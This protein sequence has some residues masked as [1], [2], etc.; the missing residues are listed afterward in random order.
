MP[1]QENQVDPTVLDDLM[2]KCADLQDQISTIQNTRNP[3]DPEDKFSLER[4]KNQTNTAE[5]SNLPPIQ[6]GAF[7]VPFVSSLK[8]LRTQQFFGQT[9]FT[10]AW[11][12][13]V[14]DNLSH[15]SIY[16]VNAISNNTAPLGPFTCKTSPAQVSIPAQGVSR[17]T[18][19]VQTVLNNGFTSDLFTGPSCTGVTTDDSSTIAISSLGTGVAGQLITWD[20]AN[21]S[22]VIGPGTANFILVGSGAGAVPQFKSIAT[23]NLTI[24][25][26]NLT[27][28]GQIP[29][30]SAAGTLNAISAGT[31]NFFLIG[32]GAGN[33][34]AFASGATL[35]IVV[36]RN[37]LT[38]LGQVPYVA[39]SG[40]L[41]VV[42]V[43]A[44]NSFFVGQGAGSA[45]IFATATTLD[46]VVGRSTLTTAGQVPVVG[47]G[48]TLAT[49]TYEKASEATVST[50]DATVTTLQTI[51]VP[52][53]TTIGIETLIVARRTGGA[54]G[55]A[56]DGA[57]YKISGVYK[58]VAGTATIIGVTTVLAD[59][60]QAAWDA[61]LD[62]TGANVRLRVTGAVNNNINW[63]STTQTYAIA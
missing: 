53:T 55:T 63:A 30:V 33:P 52:A 45:P 47:S 58:N 32:Q 60:D 27:A 51:T 42:S 23:L 2:R 26:S 10:L 21:T 12:D 17:V 38:T 50:T 61:T 4:L 9:Q 22:V 59:E 62:V 29:Y 1:G 44:L 39:S 6:K 13:P 34:P 11:L 31:L 41:G 46:L 54:A 35:D 48:G 57:R 43:G 20:A 18:F 7:R 36:G 15:F 28:V 8:L 16:V 25:A 40:T 56:E 19:Y 5:G 37:T 3:I 49:R 24:G 14:I